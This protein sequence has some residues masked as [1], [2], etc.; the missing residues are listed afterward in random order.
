[1]WYKSTYLIHYGWNTCGEGTPNS[2]EDQSLVLCTLL[3]R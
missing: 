2:S 3:I 1:M